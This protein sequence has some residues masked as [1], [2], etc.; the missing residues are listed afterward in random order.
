MQKLEAENKVIYLQNLYKDLHL[1]LQPMILSVP[2]TALLAYND[3]RF[4]VMT[5]VKALDLCF[6][7]IQV[8]KLQY[9][10]LK[11]FHNDN[12]CC[13]A[14]FA[15]SGI[16]S[17]DATQIDPPCDSKRHTPCTHVRYKRKHRLFN[18]KYSMSGRIILHYLC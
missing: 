1:T 8:S 10:S 4:K 7:L 14:V 12:E 13:R 3:Y 5:P 17:Q 6:K 11:F 16:A 9:Y 18:K 15:V 2:G